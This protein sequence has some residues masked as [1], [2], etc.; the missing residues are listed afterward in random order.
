MRK[1]GRRGHAAA[2]RTSRLFLAAVAAA[3]LAVVVAAA[4]AWRPAAPSR[5]GVARPAAR[6]RP[7][8]P[9]RRR[10]PARPGPATAD[11]RPGPAPLGRPPHARR[12]RGH[13]PGAAGG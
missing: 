9:P 8:G 5:R 12:D 7:P 13:R 2:V 6:P 3:A 1:D 11:R 4:A 10:R